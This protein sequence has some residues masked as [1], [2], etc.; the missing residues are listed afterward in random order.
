MTRFEQ[1]VQRGLAQHGD[2]W[3]ASELEDRPAFVAWF[4]DGRRIKVRWT[5]ESGE[6]Y[7]RTGRVST[8][9]GWKPAWILMHRS[10]DHGSSDVLGPRDEVVAYQ[11]SNGRGYTTIARFVD[12]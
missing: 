10:S 7:E 1:R 5:S 9:T 8:T 4:N 12:A 3:D 6:T 11:N 2:K